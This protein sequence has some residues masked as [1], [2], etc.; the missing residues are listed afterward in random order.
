MGAELGS[1]RRAEQLVGCVLSNA[2]EGLDG[3]QIVALNRLYWSVGSS[4]PIPDLVSEVGSLLSPEQFRTAVSR[5]AELSDA[6]PVSSTTDGDTVDS[7]IASALES[8]L[9]DRSTVEVEIAT[10]VAERLIGWSKA[11]G[12]FVAAPNHHPLGHPEF[13]GVRQVRRCT[14]GGRSRRRVAEAGANKTV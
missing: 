4:H 5:F 2:D 3:R 10:A 1:I 9:K 14:Q 7:R 11:F 12:I 8:R 13:V 6:T